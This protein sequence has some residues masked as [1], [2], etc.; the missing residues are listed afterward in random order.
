[1]AGREEKRR[2]EERWLKARASSR[3][4]PEPETEAVRKWWM[5]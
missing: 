5:Q 4:E 1:M 2:K 3:L